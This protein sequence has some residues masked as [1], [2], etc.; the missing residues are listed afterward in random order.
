VYELISSLRPYFFSLREIERNVSLD[1]KI[2]GR[3]K[4]ENVQHIAAQYKSVALKVQDKNDKNQLISII[5]VASEDG[6]QT[7]RTC[8]MEIIKY[9]NELEE[10][11][12]LFREKVRELEA[13]FKKESLDKLKDIT[14]I[15][16]DGQENTEGINLVE[17]GDGEGSEGSDE[18]QEE[19]D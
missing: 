4:I 7:V 17:K 10:K 19:D 6:Y 12:R 1:I 15:E 5:S 11:D 8:A 3:W 9:N 14:F 18:P 13:L 2:P 16:E